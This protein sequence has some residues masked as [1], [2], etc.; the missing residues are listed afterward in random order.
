MV[1]RTDYYDDPLAPAPNSLVVAV[2]AF[3]QD[4]VGRVLLI[5]RTDN[6]LWSIPGGAQELGETPKAAVI[7]EALEETGVFIEVIGLVGIYSD[8]RHVIAYDDGEV[9]QEF[10][11]CY[12]ATMP[13][14]LRQPAMSRES[15]SGWIRPQ[16]PL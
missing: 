5:E 12:R 6:G 1:S 7:R 13:V 11:I 9:R 3:V 16:S 15:F 2:S 14:G 8:P 4:A 10:S